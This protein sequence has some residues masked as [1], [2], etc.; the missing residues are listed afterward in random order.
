MIGPLSAGES[1]N[2]IFAA[3]CFHC[4]D[5]SKNVCHTPRPQPHLASEAPLSSYIGGK[6][7]NP[8]RRTGTHILALSAAAARPI[9]RSCDWRSLFAAVGGSLHP[10]NERPEQGSQ[11]RKPD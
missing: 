3:C 2:L 7:R 5:L 4:L 9:S 1:L 11:L 10:T 6:M 8:M